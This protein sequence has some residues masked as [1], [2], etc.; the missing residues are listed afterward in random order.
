MY[1]D[2]VTG[3]G[4]VPMKNDHKTGVIPW[5][6]I[7]SAVVTPVVE[8][9]TKHERAIRILKL[10]T[11]FSLFTWFVVGAIIYHVHYERTFHWDRGLGLLVLLSIFVYSY[12][13]YALV[14]RRAWR[15][16]FGSTKIGQK[17]TKEVV[18]PVLDKYTEGKVHKV[19]YILF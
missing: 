16:L 12:L 9:C 10:A 2:E 13:L 11:L 5:A 6:R 4:C 14:I 17:F 19:Y 8:F 1:T 18:T 15:W 3:Q 7:K